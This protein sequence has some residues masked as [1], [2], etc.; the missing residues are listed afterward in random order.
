MCQLVECLHIQNPDSGKSV[1]HIAVSMPGQTHN[2][3]L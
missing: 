2:H 3:K 1:M